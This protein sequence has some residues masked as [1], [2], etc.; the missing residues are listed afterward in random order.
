MGDT[1][2]VF[3]WGN[4]VY[5]VADLDRILEDEAVVLDTNPVEILTWNRTTFE[6]FNSRHIPFGLRRSVLYSDAHVLEGEDARDLAIR[7]KLSVA[8]PINEETE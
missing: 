3:S 5:R 7:L 2:W 6:P 8:S 1:S 4:Q